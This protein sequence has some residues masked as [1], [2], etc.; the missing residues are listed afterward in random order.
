MTIVIDTVSYDVPFV[1]LRRKAD[2]LYKNAERLENGDLAAELL[3]VYKNY[4]LTMGSPN[5][6]T[7]LAAYNALWAKLTEAQAF[8]EVTVPDQAPYQ[9]YFAGVS[10]ELRKEKNGINFWKGLTVTFIAKSP[11]LIP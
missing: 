5:N 7:Q 11:A 8:H 2:F 9:A 1:S 6:S 10:D 3:G 4:E